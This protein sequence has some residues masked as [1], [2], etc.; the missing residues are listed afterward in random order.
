VA[1][2]RRQGQ[3]NHPNLDPTRCIIRFSFS[4]YRRKFADIA[5]ALMCLFCS[6]HFTFPDITTLITSDEVQHENARMFV[7]IL[8]IQVR[9]DDIIIWTR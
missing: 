2:W 4:G 9:D 3:S 7:F 6:V 5:F 8:R 1:S